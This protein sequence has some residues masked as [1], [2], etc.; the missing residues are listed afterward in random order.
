MTKRAYKRVEVNIE[1]KWKGR[2]SEER[3]ELRSLGLGGCFIQTKELPAVGELVDIRFQHSDG[4]EL[5][6][7]G[8]VVYIVPKSGFGMQFGFLST[9]YVNW[10][11]KL[12]EEEEF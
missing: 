7:F 3:A 6:I 9:E 1:V 2:Y 12:I 11:L 5:Q 8:K 4:E 10:L